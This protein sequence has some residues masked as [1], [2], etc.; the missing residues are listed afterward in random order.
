MN[1]KDAASLDREAD[2]VFAVGMLLA[3]PGEHRINIRRLRGDV[4]HVGRNKTPVFQPFDF[5]R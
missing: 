5:W 2:F 1:V 4:D 3:E